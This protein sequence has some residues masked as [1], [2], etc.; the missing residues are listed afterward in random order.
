MNRNEWIELVHKAGELAALPELYKKYVLKNASKQTRDKLRKSIMSF[1]SGFNDFLA[2]I[3]LSQN[4]IDTPFFIEWDQIKVWLDDKHPHW[5]YAKRQIDWLRTIGD[6]LLENGLA[7]LRIPHFPRRL[8]RET[9]CYLPEELADQIPFFVELVNQAKTRPAIIIPPNEQL[10]A[11][12]QLVCGAAYQLITSG[13]IP[14]NNLAYILAGFKLSGLHRVDGKWF[15]DVDSGPEQKKGKASEETSVYQRRWSLSPESVTRL[16][17]VFFNQEQEGADYLIGAPFFDEHRKPCKKG[18]RILLTLKL[19]LWIDELTK[20]I[21][22]KTG[23]DLP[24]FKPSQV[25]SMSRVLAALATSPLLLAE[26]LGRL[27]SRAVAKPMLELLVKP[28]KYDMANVDLNTPFCSSKRGKKKIKEQFA[29][30]DDVWGGDDEPQEWEEQTVESVESYDF[31]V[32]ALLKSVKSEARKPARQRTA[33]KILSLGEK[34][35]G[36]DPIP[37]GQNNESNLRYHS[38][39]AGAWAAKRLLDGNKPKIVE[40]QYA[41]IRDFLLYNLGQEPLHL[42]PSDELEIRILNV[43]S[44]YDTIR[45]RNLALG[46]FKRFFKWLDKGGDNFIPG[47]L[48]PPKVNWNDPELSPVSIL[49]FSDMVLPHEFEALMKAINKSYPPQK[50]SEYQ[51]MRLRLKMLAILAF[52]CGL[53]RMEVAHLK[54]RDFMKG[55]RIRLSVNKSKSISGRR[56]IPLSYLFDGRALNVFEEYWDTFS[57]ETGPND[58]FVPGAYSLVNNLMDIAHKLLERRVNY[59]ILR[60]SFGTLLALRLLLAQDYFAFNTRTYGT[61]LGKLEKSQGKMFSIKSLEALVSGLYGDAGVDS[62]V[63]PIPLVSRLMGHA[64]PGITLSTYVHILDFLAANVRLHGDVEL[65]ARTAAEMLNLS[66]GP[67]RKKLD[68]VGAAKKPRARHV[69]KAQIMQLQRTS[70][71]LHMDESIMAN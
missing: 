15:M 46:Q 28:N 42:L 41:R 68:Q 59:H 12:D 37:S 57:I 48:P 53:R 3:T 70:S 35:W 10:S 40:Q 64:E 22:K 23:W 65:E 50:G 8:R 49:D 61:L 39:I 33:K 2:E 19:Q 18:P 47:L 20:D 58:Y 56:N 31:A 27:N 30:A 43:I 29:S 1:Q 63:Q 11:Y 17:A 4:Q 36:A 16:L 51:Q 24:R 45:S 60:H 71:W 13:D 67:A 32:Q 25:I 44:S 38:A 62:L 9:I 66:A 21:N 6:K 14:A 55:K 7:E 52:W 26:R 5:S 69:L 54:W 34:H